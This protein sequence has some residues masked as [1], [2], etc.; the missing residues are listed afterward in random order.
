LKHFTA[1]L[2]LA[3]SLGCAVPAAAQNAAPLTVEHAWAR[4]SIGAARPAVAYMTLVNSGRKAVRLV[5]V[6]TPVADRVEAHR[7]MLKGDVMRMQPAGEVEVPAGERVEFAPGGLHFMLMDLKRPLNAGDSFPMT[8]RF[9]DGA[10]VDV[11]VE[12][13]GPG[14][15]GP[16]E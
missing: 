9:S 1:L 13:F 16:A 5:T 3:V 12:V 11:T 14:A 15:Q 2:L 6:E 8:L 4:A 10:A 7:T